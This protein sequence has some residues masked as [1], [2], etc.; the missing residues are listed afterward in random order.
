V[1]SFLTATPLPATPNGIIRSK[2]RAA[3]A[4]CLR[5][6]SVSFRCD[7][8]TVSEW[9]VSSTAAAAAATEESARECSEDEE[10]EESVSRHLTPHSNELHCA[11]EGDDGG[12]IVAVWTDGADSAGQ[13]SCTSQHRSNRRRSSVFRLAQ[14]F[15]IINLI[16]TTREVLV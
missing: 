7:S 13:L 6:H 16:E 15:S 14:S 3:P 12:D 8:P 9:P 11:S 1:S 5:Q 2:F 10:V 4:A